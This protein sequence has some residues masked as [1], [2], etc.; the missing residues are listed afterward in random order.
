MIKLPNNI[1]DAKIRK[2]KKLFSESDISVFTIKKIK[3]L[4]TKAKLNALFVVKFILKM[5]ELKI[6]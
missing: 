5:M 1:L 6:I 4:A 2:N 3:S